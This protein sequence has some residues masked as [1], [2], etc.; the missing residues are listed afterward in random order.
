M[1]E[2][3]GR[4]EG[5]SLSDGYCD[6]TRSKLGPPHHRKC[7]VV[8]KFAG[9]CNVLDGLARFALENKRRAE[10][11]DAGLGSMQLKQYMG[12]QPRQIR[13]ILPIALSS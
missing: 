12:S 2:A 5:S 7:R 13:N 8:V 1:N 11:I 6:V 9:A 10:V 4:L 3:R